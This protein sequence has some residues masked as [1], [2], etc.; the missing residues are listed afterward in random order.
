MNLID[1]INYFFTG[2]SFDTISSITTPSYDIAPIRF[3]VRRKVEMAI[4]QDKV[5]HLQ[6]FYDN[7][8]NKRRKLSDKAIKQK[9][10]NGRFVKE[11]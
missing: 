4:F 10:Y 2:L 6:E 11:K 7:E 8:M 3:I 9:R 1:K 5:K